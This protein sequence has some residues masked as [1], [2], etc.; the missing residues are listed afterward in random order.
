M[1]M[2]SAVVNATT[3][4]NTAPSESSHLDVHMTQAGHSH[5]T[6]LVHADLWCCSLLQTRS[7]GVPILQIHPEK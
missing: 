2:H 3:R 4:M 6:R 5:K 1:T 7:R